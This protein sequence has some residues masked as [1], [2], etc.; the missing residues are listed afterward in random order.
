LRGNVEANLLNRTFFS[1]ANIQILQ[2]RIRREVYEK[3]GNR[4]VI[5]PQSITE[6]EI[7]MR[8]IY[9]QHGKNWPTRIAEQVDELNGLVAEYSVPKILNEVE[10]YIFYRAHASDHIPVPMELP[11]NVSRA[12]TR[13][14]PMPPLL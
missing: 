2:N 6:L 10:N 14:P 11:Q 4:F 3:S 8:A 7:V 1:T 9:L 12:G 5:S 13:T